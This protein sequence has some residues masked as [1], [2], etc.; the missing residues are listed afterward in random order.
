MN[1][2]AAKFD[3]ERVYLLWVDPSLKDVMKE[4]VIL[5][6]MSH[7]LDYIFD[8]IGAA[9][10]DTEIRAYA[11]DHLYSLVRYSNKRQTK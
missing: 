7:I 9:S 8:E 5:H 1:G 2:F 4:R 6:E 3:R 10:V 11:L